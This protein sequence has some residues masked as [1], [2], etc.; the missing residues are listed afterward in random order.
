MYLIGY[1]LSRRAAYRGHALGAER[2]PGA[3]TAK[4]VT[5]HRRADHIRNAGPMLASPRSGWSDY[6]LLRRPTDFRF[7]KRSMAK[8]MP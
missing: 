5:Q 8:W 1:S 6:D 4:R 7:K 3:A 2:G